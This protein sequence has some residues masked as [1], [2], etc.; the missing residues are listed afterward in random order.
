MLRLP[1][2]CA[3]W[4]A[5][6]PL[7]GLAETPKEVNI[8]NN[9]TKTV[10]V[11]DTNKTFDTKLDKLLNNDEVRFLFVGGKGG[12]GKTTTSS[13]IATQLALRKKVLLVSTDP[14]HSLSD[15]WRT[16]L[17]DEPKAVVVDNAVPDNLHIMQ[18]DPRKT[19]EAELADFVDLGDQMAGKIGS[20]FIPLRRVVA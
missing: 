3:A 20:R 12:V 5:V 8:V 18:L 17:S 13:A 9:T 11:F 19:L 4:A 2:L 1:S 7:S 14:A 6:F 10:E 16:E 15:A